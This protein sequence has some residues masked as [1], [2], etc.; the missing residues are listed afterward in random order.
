MARLFKK[1]YHKPGTAPGTY[2]GEGRAGAAQMSALTYDA[3][4]AHAVAASSIGDLPRRRSGEQLWLHLQGTPDALQLGELGARFGLHPLALEDVANTG[5]RPKL[6]PYEGN[7]FV[8][9]GMPTLESGQLQVAEISLFLGPDFV[10]SICENAHDPFVEVRKR[11][12]NGGGRLRQHTVDFLFYALIDTVVDHAYPV[13]EEM[14]ET[15]EALEVELLDRPDRDLLGRLHAIKRE[16]I[17]LRRQMWPARDLL[18]QVMR[19]DLPLLHPETL[20]YFRDAHD[21]AVQIIDLI[22]SYRDITASLLDVY[23]SSMSHR[24]NDI[25]RVLT[26]ITTVFMPLT[27]IAG[28]YGMNFVANEHSWWAMPEIRTT[29]GYPVVILTMAVIAGGMLGLFRRYGWLK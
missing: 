12:L 27:F 8:T 20:G 19:T 6:D 3:Q 28:V 11:L 26:V 1:R 9:L 10:I 17:L 18:A 5:Q 29:Y 23:L 25:M 16:L 21:H 14:G 15:I 13:L 7:L 22:E 24:L 2:H 4:G